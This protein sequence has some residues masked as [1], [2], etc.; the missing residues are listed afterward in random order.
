MSDLTL[1]RTGLSDKQEDDY[2]VIDGGKAVGRIYITSDGFRGAGYAWFVYGSSRHGFADTLEEA[3]AG[4]RPTMARNV[5]EAR[6]IPWEASRDKWG[7]AVRYDDHT[8]EA[9]AV[10][11]REAAEREVVR[12]KRAS[13]RPI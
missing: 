9:Y 10:G 13:L 8:R 5:I 6:V 12:L 4:G 1:R 2:H 11:D 3:K 7:V